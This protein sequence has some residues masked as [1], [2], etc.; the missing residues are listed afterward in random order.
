MNKTSDVLSSNF[1]VYI[2]FSLRDHKLYTGYTTNL[3]Q[4]IIEHEKGYVSATKHRRPLKLIFYESFTD[5]RDAKAREKFLKSGFGRDHIKQ[6]LKKTL[7]NL[8]YKNL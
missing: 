8:Q 2:L 7:E 1:Y 6:A 3:N 5:Q 4:R